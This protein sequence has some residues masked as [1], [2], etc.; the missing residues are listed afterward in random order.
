LRQ[1]LLSESRQSIWLTFSE[2]EVIL[3]RELPASASKFTSWWSNDISTNV[4]PSQARAWLHAGFR[5]KASIKRR[6]VEFR[7][8]P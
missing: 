7:R 6:V 8:M 3:G 2:I 1:S 4:A 5:A